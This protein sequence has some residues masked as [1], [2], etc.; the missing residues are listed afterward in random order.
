ME[1]LLVVRQIK[2]LRIFAQA[3][4]VSLDGTIEEAERLDGISSTPLARRLLMLDAGCILLVH[5]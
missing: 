1:C 3:L 5:V 2:V 4:I